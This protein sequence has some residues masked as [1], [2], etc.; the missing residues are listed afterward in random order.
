MALVEHYYGTGLSDAGPDLAAV[1]D[2]LARARPK[3][4]AEALCSEFPAVSWFDPRD[5]AAAV[6]IC[7]RCSV[8]SECG[9]YA[10]Q[11]DEAAGVWAGVV[12]DPPR[13]P[14]RPR[15]RVVSDGAPARLREVGLVEIRSPTPSPPPHQPGAPRF[16]PAQKSVAPTSRGHDE[17]RP[18]AP[19]SCAQ[20]PMAVKKGKTLCKGCE[21]AEQSV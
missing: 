15:S 4:Q 21:R 2:L 5:T 20:C 17:D 6:A 10:R 16:M 14:Q 7:R 1:L 12:L 13:R 9:S 11:N 18:P 19:A 8:A 3:W